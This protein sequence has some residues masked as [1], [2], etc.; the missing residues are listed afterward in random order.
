[1]CRADRLTLLCCAC[2]VALGH[3]ARPIMDYVHWWLEL[4]P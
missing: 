3:A 4:A 2:I 1:M